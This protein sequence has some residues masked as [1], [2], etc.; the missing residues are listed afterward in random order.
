MA[1]RVGTRMLGKN[2]RRRL[3]ENKRRGF[4]SHELMRPL[5]LT[6]STSKPPAKDNTLLHV[7]ELR[8][9][10]LVI[11]LPLYHN[12]DR[13]G[14][15]M[16]VERGVLEQ[17][18]AE[19]RQFCSGYRVYEGEGWC[20]SIRFRGDFDEHIRIEIEALFNDADIEFLKCWK[21]ELE[22]RFVQDSIYMSLYGP[23]QW[24]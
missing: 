12:A 17:T 20:H 2:G 16:P 6:N 13:N 18:F 24:I 4:P 7:D 11:L 3:L 15:R 10:V 22:L 1:F 21:R 8:L 19:I 23:V 5:A 14:N 9:Q